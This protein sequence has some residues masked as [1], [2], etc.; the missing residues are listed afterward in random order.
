MDDLIAS[1]IIK[2][3]SYKPSPEELEK[4]REVLALYVFPLQE[5]YKK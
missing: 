3:Q 1:K 5:W 4:I 2:D